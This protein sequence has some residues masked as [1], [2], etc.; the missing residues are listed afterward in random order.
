[1]VHMAQVKDGDH[2]KVH[3]TGKLDDGTVFD[4]S[5]CAEDECGCGHGPIEFTVGSGQVIP[6][7]EAGVMGL[8]EGESKTIHIPVEE[9]Y[10]E[11]REEMVAVVPRTELPPE[12]KPEVGQQLEVTQ[13]DGQ[14]FQVTITS[15]TDDTITIDANHPLAGQAL[16]FDLKVVKIN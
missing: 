6:G 4:S 9:A 3:Y 11:R 7:F 16:N 5:E 1:M 15:V 8:S 12:M 14:V 13:E 10:G 2:V